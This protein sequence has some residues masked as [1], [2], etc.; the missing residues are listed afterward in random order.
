VI[1]V[2]RN[3]A[4]LYLSQ[5]GQ[6]TVNFDEAAKF[7]NL[8]SVFAAKEQFHIDHAE[9]V[10]VLHEPPSEYDVALPL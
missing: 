10:L 6:W 9:L 8:R 1:K 3:R 7:E 2:I 5:E 4:G